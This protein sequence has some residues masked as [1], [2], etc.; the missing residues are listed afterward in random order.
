MTG[1]PG[2]RPT[3]AGDT[4][5]AA[6]SGA[7]AAARGAVAT[8]AA[9]VLVAVAGALAAAIMQLTATESLLVARHRVVE[10]A[11][12]AADT[13]AADVLATL[14]AGWGLDPVL[15]GPDGIGGSE[16]DGTV[17]ASDD[18]TA[19]TSAAAGGRLILHVEAHVPGGRR[20][21]DALVGRDPKP[22]DEAL[23]WLEDAGGLGPLV[24]LLEIQG[25]RDP[26]AKP[27]SSI[28]AP[29]APEALDAWLIGQAA[30]VD[31]AATVSPPRFA[32]PPPLEELE[33]R[34]RSVAVPGSGT[35]V[36]AGI[37]PVTITFADGDLAVRTAAVGAG[38]LFVSGRLDIEGALAFT[39]VVVARG[40]VRVA[41]GGSLFIE[42]AL[43][44]DGGSPSLDVAGLL[45]LRAAADALDLADGTLALPR[46]PRILGIR[47]PG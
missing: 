39:G 43:W 2:A 5:A 3:R 28:A 22:F 47:D 1:A 26:S 24:G 8:M 35:L 21:V 31:V 15:A 11:L 25:P 4:D 27:V 46:L 38:L 45:H 29:T 10:R 37:P 40:G 33:A 30:R 6:S 9:L 17:R 41:S 20:R 18:C 13:C 23:L 14:P 36:P 42:G 19:S 34:V 32:P 44:L 12:M 16:D 7:H